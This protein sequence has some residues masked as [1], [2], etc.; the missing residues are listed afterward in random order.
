MM[1]IICFQ[2][3]W[4]KL[5]YNNYT[6]RPENLFFGLFILWVFD[7]KEPIQSTAAERELRYINHLNLKLSV[8]L[9]PK[10][11]ILPPEIDPPIFKFHL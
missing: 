11:N 1:C 2:T 9:F 6:V 8:N 10:K 5:I 4:N 7:V 3:G